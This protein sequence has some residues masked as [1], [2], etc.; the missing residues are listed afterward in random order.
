MAQTLTSLLTHIV[1]STKH[2]ADLITTAIEPELYAYLGGIAENQQSVLLAAGGTA[3]H[4]HLLVSL[5]KNIALKDLMQS[6]KGDSSKWLKTKGDEFSDFHWQD[7]YAAFSLGQSQVPNT[8]AYLAKQKVHH[9]QTPFE[10]ELK[11][12]LD[13]YG[14]AYDE[15]YLWT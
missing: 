7:G 13:K 12:F 11:L 2:R 1:F 6:L 8:R 4:I 14:I 3:N 15:Q 10:D 9:Q 5:S